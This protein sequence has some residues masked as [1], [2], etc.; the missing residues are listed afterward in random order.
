MEQ[1]YTEDTFLAKWLSKELTEED[2]L[3]FEKTPAFKEYQKIIKK[4]DLFEAPSFQQERVY[5]NILEKT[6]AKPKAKVKSLIPNWVSAVAASV[7]ILFGLFFFMNSDTEY[8][9]GFGEQLA[10]VLPDG[11]KVELNAKSILSFDKDEWKA[12]KRNLFLEGEAYFKVKKGSKF[13]VNT[14]SGDVSVLGTQ[15]NVKEAKA[16]FE[17]KCFEGKVSV[18]N[19]TDS[20]ILTPG[21]GYRK[22][23]D[24]ASEKLIFETTAPTWIAGE[25]TFTNA[26][27][28][29]VLEELEKQFQI[30]FE[31]DL[32]NTDRVFTGSFSNKNK[33]LALQTVC[34]PLGFKFEV[35]EK[36][37][38]LLSKK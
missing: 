30:Q 8:T 19:T 3:A 29:I 7:A 10:V 31:V 14:G 37:T 21:K 25:S 13:T 11:S 28:V 2:R 9:T 33:E 36:N 4:M 32:I 38:I 24:K 5:K 16:Y 34:A 23:A 35:T 12:G 6:Q 20:E 27:L 22:V 26:P 15:F 1:K 18:V 17:V